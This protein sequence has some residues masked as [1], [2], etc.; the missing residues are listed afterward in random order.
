MAFAEQSQAVT[1]ARTGCWRRMC[2]HSPTAAGDLRAARRC[3][4]KRE[5]FKPKMAKVKHHRPRNAAVKQEDSNT[6]MNMEKQGMSSSTLMT[7]EH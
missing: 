5:V 6:E 4:Q 7:A 3:L 1:P 2:D